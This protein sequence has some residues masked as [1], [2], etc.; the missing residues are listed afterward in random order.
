MSNCRLVQMSS[1]AK[2]KT[3]CEKFFE[4]SCDLVKINNFGAPEQQ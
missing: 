1:E 2:N 3:L 4:Y